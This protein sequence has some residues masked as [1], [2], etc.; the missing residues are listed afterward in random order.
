MRFNGK[1]GLMLT[2]TALAFVTPA[3]VLA[4]DAGH[5]N[6]AATLASPAETPWLNK[7][8]SAETR[9]ELLL[10]EMTQAEKLTLVFGHFASDGEWL[11]ERGD[12][13]GLKWTQ[14]EESRHQSAGFVYG[15]PRLGIPN[16]WLTDAGIGVA[17]QRGDNPRLRTALP[18]GIAT[19]ATWD[20]QLAHDGGAMIGREA[21]LSGFNVQLAGGINTNRDPRN[22]RTFEYAGEDPLL[23]GIMVGEQIKGIQSNNIVSTIKHLAFNNQE[24]NRFTIDVKIDDAPARMSELLAFQIGIEVGNPG[25]V[26]CSYNIVNGQYGCENNWLLNEVL[27]QDWGYK[28]YVMSDWGATHSTI[29]AANNGLDQQSGWPFDKGPYFK[30]PLKEAVDNGFVK[31]ERLDDMARRIL[32]ALF[33]T[34]VIDNPVPQEVNDAAIDFEAHAK[35][36]QADAEG[37][38]V[39]LKN[40][41]N[42]LPLAANAKKIVVIGGHADKGV[43]SGGGSSQVYGIGGNPVAGLGLGPGNDFPGPLT[44]YPD[45][46]LDALKARTTAEVIYHDGANI[47]AAVSAARGA[48]VV[49]IFGTQ[50]TGE[51]FDAPLKIDGNGDQLISAV[52]KAN[53]KTVV[54]LQTG[55][56][57]L[58]PWLKDAG[59]VIEAWYP[60]TRGG[61]AIARVLTGEVNPSG[62]LPV[63]FPASESQ[64]PRPVLD[65]DITQPDLRPT[66]DYNIEGAA[67]GY[68]WHD[69]HGLKVLFP[70]GHGLSYTQF[71]YSGL[72]TDVVDGKLTARFTVTNS[73]KRDGS[74]VP[75]I[76]VS[77]V[78]GGWEAPKRL[79]AFDKVHLKAGESQTVS[80][81]V[82]PRLLANYD[83][84]SKTWNIA[85]GEYEVKLNRSATDQV[86]AVRVILPAQKYDVNGK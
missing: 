50:W 76:Y 69:K 66:T 64:L 2:A 56:P 54:V 39:L 65:G 75:Q 82:D 41:R 61:T 38:I 67:V 1:I 22:G 37:G 47:K 25:S 78:N 77:P 27:K 32:W 42:L 70:F 7:A 49:I 57:V 14:P 15:V 81:T 13:P 62:R 74:D 5:A 35:I 43:I 4:Q 40:D 11:N 17:S 58:M 33:E 44:Y 12:I 73:G 55:G 29:P 36:T 21:R 6:R 28:G 30:G 20:R 19:A 10:K 52:A 34:G 63:T 84:A 86:A 18:S 45:A 71:T 31:A 23:A 53:K 72:T 9:A 79:G 24:T 68:R 16:Q 48:D 51:S 83:S 59:A 85:A 80:V 60:G 26:M 46:P 8:L 3:G